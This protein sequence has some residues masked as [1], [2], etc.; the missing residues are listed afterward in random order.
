VKAVTL[1][2]PTRA[3]AAV[4]ATG[5]AS[6]KRRLVVLYDRDCGLCTATAKRLRRWDRDGR[7][8]LLSLQDAEV[9]DRQDVADTARTHPVLAKLHVLD[10]ASGRVDAGGDAALAIAAALPGGWL[11][12]PFRRIAPV[13]W[14]VGA[15][16]DFVANH[17]H[18]IGGWLGLEEP[19]CDTS[20]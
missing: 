18:A 3:H 1:T 10:E 19:A 2:Q 14:I 6:G 4:T 17:R 11:V 12:R 7:L 16:Y 9:S 5:T 15:F 13:R 20:Q 8:E